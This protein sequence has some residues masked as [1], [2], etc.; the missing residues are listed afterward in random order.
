M[1]LLLV[2]K[3]Y[4]EEACRVWLGTKTFLFVHSR[5][6]EAYVASTSP[7]H[8]FTMRF[9]KRV[10]LEADLTFMASRI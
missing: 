9:I 2:N 10:I 4:F 7:V 5:T 8:L 6:F 3:Q 1:S